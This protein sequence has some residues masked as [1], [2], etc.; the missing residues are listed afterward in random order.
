MGTSRVQHG[1]SLLVGCGKG[2]GHETSLVHRLLDLGD[3]S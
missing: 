3:S 1:G 2:W